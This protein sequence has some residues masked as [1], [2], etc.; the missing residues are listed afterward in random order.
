MS[1]KSKKSST[2]TRQT[3]KA[4]AFEVEAEKLAHAY[5]VIVS[6]EDGA[7]FGRGLELPNV[8]GGGST[9]AQCIEDTRSAMTALLAYMIEKGERPPPAARSGVRSEQVNVRLSAHEKA[10]LE[11]LAKAKGFKGIADLLR[12]SALDRVA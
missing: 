11:Q 8:F 10:R 6:F 7:W 1:V 2:K 9:A 5:Q 4:N 3:S 12:A